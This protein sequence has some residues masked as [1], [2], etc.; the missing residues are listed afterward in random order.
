MFSVRG[1][2]SGLIPASVICAF[3][4]QHKSRM[5]ANLYSN[6]AMLNVI[7]DAKKKG[8]EDETHIAEREE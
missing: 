8:P 4:S 2:P 5:D 1:R 6:T 3:F 7:E